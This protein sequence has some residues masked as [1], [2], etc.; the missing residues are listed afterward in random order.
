ML[1]IKTI[2]YTSMFVF[3]TEFI[4]FFF[5]VVFYLFILTLKTH[6]HLCLSEPLKLIINIV[7]MQLR[8]LNL[9]TW[10]FFIVHTLIQIATTA[11]TRL[12]ST[13]NK[14]FQFI[15]FTAHTVLLWAL[16]AAELH[17]CMYSMS[18]SCPQRCSIVQLPEV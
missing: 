12:T 1:L 13:K 8:F 6:Q 9:L 4:M 10:Y 11:W 3:S 15:Y 16:S 17:E 2:N 18:C 5:L 7:S 14:S